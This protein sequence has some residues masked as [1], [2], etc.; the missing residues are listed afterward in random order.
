MNNNLSL[1]F[2][3]K[4]IEHFGIKMYS[5]LPSALAE[6]IANGYDANATEVNI[7]LFNQKGNFKV[8]VTDNGDGMSFE[9]INQNFLIIGRRRRDFDNKLTILSKRQIT[10]RKGLGKLA[11]FGIGN[12]IEIKT[13]KRGTNKSIKFTMDW[14]QILKQNSG[15]YHPEYEITSNSTKRY[16]TSITVSNLKRKSDFNLTE[17]K[18]S[19]SKLFNLFDETF[20]VYISK[21]NSEK[22]L[23]T[24]EDRIQGIEKQYEWN[25]NEIIKREMPNFPH[26]NLMKGTIFSSKKP[27]NTNL[28]GI[29]LYARGR[30]AN[31]ASF[32]GHNDSGHAFSY[33]T[34]W[35]DADYIDNEEDDYISTDRQMIDWES[36]LTSKLK[37]ALHIVL[38]FIVKNWSEKRSNDKI[39]NIK[40][41]ENFDVKEWMSKVPKDVNKNLENIFNSISKQPQVSEETFQYIVL[42]IRKIVPENTYYHYRMLHNEI[43]NA[44]KKYYEQGDYHTAFCEAF[45]RY[46]NKVKEKSKTNHNNDSGIMEKSFGDDGLLTITKKIKERYSKKLTETTLKNIENGQKSLSLGVIMG[47]RHIVSHEEIEILQDSDLFTEKDC[48]DLLSLLSHLLRRLENFEIR[49][50]NF[51]KKGNN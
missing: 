43:K 27:L 33:I 44:S 51:N 9:E 23:I 4:T 6:I 8:V 34:G 13:H 36:E 21:N 22:Y 7:E 16:G 39:E 35:I 49:D 37:E 11:L 45:K 1:K 40:K 50:T 46:K 2:D 41:H 47:A 32:F 28:K 29:T 30:Q 18:F 17:I 5:R 14:D 42:N 48:L 38:K 26:K 25:V 19:L 10:G 24:R 3:P 15:E 31:E 20:K 12:T